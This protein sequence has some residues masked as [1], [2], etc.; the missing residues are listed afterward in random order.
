MDRNHEGHH[1]DAWL[2]LPADGNVC[3]KCDDMKSMTANEA[4]FL[5]LRSLCCHPVLI[6][7]MNRSQLRATS[8]Y[9]K[10]PDLGG[11]VRVKLSLHAKIHI[12]AMSHIDSIFLFVQRS[13]PQ[14]VFRQ[15]AQRLAHGPQVSHHPGA[16][17][18]VQHQMIHPP[19]VARASILLFIP[20]S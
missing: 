16:Q 3:N 5:S 11:Q 7:D 4:A 14:G 6:T 19:S 9:E 2:G 1:D 13:R 20:C 12:Q 17:H 8:S 18:N 10:H 15:S